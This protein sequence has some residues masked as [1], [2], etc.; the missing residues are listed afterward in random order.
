MASILQASGPDAISA[1]ILKETSNIITPI[2]Q[3]IFQIS[4]DTGRVPADW[5]TAFITPIFKKGSRTVPSNYQPVSL[6]CITS[7]LFEHYHL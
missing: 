5:T 2:L 6:T 1:T 3:A 7:K 4:L